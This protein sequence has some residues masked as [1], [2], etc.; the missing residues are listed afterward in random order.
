MKRT[1]SH[2]VL[3]RGDEY[4]SDDDNGTDLW[5]KDR[6]M[7]DLFPAKTN[8]EQIAAWIARSGNRAGTKLIPVY[9]CD[10]EDGQEETEGTP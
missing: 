10:T 1:L 3:K 9:F 8:V 5:S 2:F 6:Y 4:Y 7:A